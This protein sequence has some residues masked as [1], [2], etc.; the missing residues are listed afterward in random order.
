MYIEELKFDSVLVNIGEVECLVVRG[1]TPS[2]VLDFGLVLDITDSN[3]DEGILRSRF[4]LA[5]MSLNLSVLRHVSIF[6]M[7]T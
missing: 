2:V 6:R 1:M 5:T 3:F 7:V 4:S